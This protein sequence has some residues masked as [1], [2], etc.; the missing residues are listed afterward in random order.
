MGKIIYPHKGELVNRGLKE[1]MSSENKG[2][3]IYSGDTIFI[4]D[5]WSNL[6]EF[7]CC[8]NSETVWNSV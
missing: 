7:F 4:S 1:G 3:G 5:Q 6:F 2:K 8:Q